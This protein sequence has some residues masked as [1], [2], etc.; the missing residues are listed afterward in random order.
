MILLLGVIAVAVIWAVVTYNR[1]VALRNQ[2]QNSFSQIDVQ[3]KRR[4]DLIPNLV[5]ATKGYL[6]HER[7]TLEAVVNARSQAM[8][9][10]QDAR[11]NPA[12]GSAIANLSAAEGM[13]TKSLGK[14]MALREDY[15]E[16]KADESVAR[17]TEELTST[18]NRISFARQAFNDQ[19]A[20]YNIDVESFPA[21]IVARATGFSRAAQLQATQSKEEREPVKVAL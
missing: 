1:F 2:N 6:K 3:F 11:S 8:T 12:D 17:L 5:N 4:Y 14:L 19:V 15:P 13:L 18:E 7:E 10:E 16:L 20:N 21:S 9:A